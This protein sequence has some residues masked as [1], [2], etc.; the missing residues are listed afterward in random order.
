MFNTDLYEHQDPELIYIIENELQKDDFSEDF[1]ALKLE[2]ESQIVKKCRCTEDCT[3]NCLHGGNYLPNSSSNDLILNENRKSLDVLYECNSLCEC[4]FD[5]RNRLV[6]FGPRKSLKIVD[7]GAKGK[8][9]ITETAIPKGAFVCEYA[10]EVL[11][12]AEAIKRNAK[13]DENGLMNYIICL[14]EARNDGK[15]GKTLQTFIDPS[16]KGN[17]GRYLNH[18]CDPNCTIIS[19]RIDSP[20][21]KLG[22]F[23]KNDIKAGDELTFHYGGETP[24]TEMPENAKKCLCKAENCMKFLP[25]WKF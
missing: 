18:S 22:I 6:V 11:T 1:Q 3:T 19:V 20:V 21:P 25:N 14:N 8:G 5:C 7:F 16:R 13:N 12:K 17:I 10:G 15:S 4:S 24:S 2:F 23:A 9:L